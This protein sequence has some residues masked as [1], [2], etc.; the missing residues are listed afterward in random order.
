MCV[1]PYVKD[2]KLHIL[3]R[4]IGF[5]KLTIM[6]LTAFSPSVGL[7]PPKK[8][9]FRLRVKSYLRKAEKVRQRVEK[10]KM[11]GKKTR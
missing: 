6:K 3:K 10:S 9:T 7:R 2:Y 1:I 4:Y 11:K 5:I 8:W